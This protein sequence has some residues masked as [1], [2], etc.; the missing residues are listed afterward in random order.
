MGVRFPAFALIVF[1]YCMSGCAEI[2]TT[3]SSTQIGA[4]APVTTNCSDRQSQGTPDSSAC[5]PALTK[6]IPIADECPDDPLK[7]AAGEC[8]CGQPDKNS[9]GDRLYDCYDGFPSKRSTTGA[10]PID[11]NLFMQGVSLTA[12]KHWHKEGVAKC[13]S[14]RQGFAWESMAH[15]DWACSAEDRNDGIESSDIFFK[16]YVRKNPSTSELEYVFL[17]NRSGTSFEIYRTSPAGIFISVESDPD[18]LRRFDQGNSPLKW[19]DRFYTSTFN[20]GQSYTVT[21]A[22]PCAAAAVQI[23]PFSADRLAGPYN[24]STSE[25]LALATAHLNKSAMPKNLSIP[26]AW[27]TSIPKALGY[28]GDVWLVTREDYWSPFI[29]GVSGDGSDPI[30]HFRYEEN[31]DYLCVGIAPDACRSVGIVGW[32]VKYHP[33]SNAAVRIL[34]HAVVT[35]VVFEN[36]P[37][38]MSKESCFSD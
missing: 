2:E 21:T 37:V 28:S 22:Q 5:I 13:F 16:N 36:V 32:R 11:M 8:G 7:S 9:D 3:Q 10:H 23:A 27:Y 24:L 18:R 4:S 1:I 14:Q 15:S 31:Y 17:K 33:T 38:T 12:D 25:D 6:Q 30:A 20:T 19:V 29:Q 34:R 35:R 26:S